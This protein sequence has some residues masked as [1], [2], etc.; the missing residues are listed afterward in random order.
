MPSCAHALLSIGDSQ[1]NHHEKDEAHPPRS[2][3]RGWFLSRAMGQILRV[4]WIIVLPLLVILVTPPAFAQSIGTLSASPTGIAFGSI[5]VGSTSPIMKTTL[6]NTGKRPPSHSP[7]M[8]YQ[9]SF[10]GA[11]PAP[12]TIPA[13]LWHREPVAPT[14][15]N[16]RQPLPES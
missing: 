2:S 5:A 13:A 7:A 12:A 11:A 15:R 14:A 3:G 6:T 10:L 9:P 8:R 16:L 1:L 4:L